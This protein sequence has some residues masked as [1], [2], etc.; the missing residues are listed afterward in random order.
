MVVCGATTLQ[1]A[2][3]NG[4]QSLLQRFLARADGPPVEYRALRHLEARNDHFSA[5]AWMEAWTEFDRSGFH[6]EIVS[7]SGNHYIRTHVLRA[8][9]EGE[10]KL[11]E[12]REPQKAALTLD[13]YLFQ[14][15]GST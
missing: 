11:W 7:E 6:Y 1:G 13:N 4:A 12:A 14:N 3:R 10:Q 2:Q 15:G 8:A 5:H 9:L